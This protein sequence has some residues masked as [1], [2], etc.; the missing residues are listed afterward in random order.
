ML[1]LHADTIDQDGGSPG[2]RDHDLLEAAV[3]MPRQEFGR[4]YFHTDLAVKAAACLF[5]IVLNHPFV[6]GNKQ[7]AAVLSSLVFLRVNG[8][9]RL[10]DPA[11]LET[12]TRQ[13]AAGEWSED[14]LTR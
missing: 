10:P 7:R 2:V 8:V 6:D 13:A 1:L 4:A 3:A 5:H 12:T 11:R 9:T 14:G